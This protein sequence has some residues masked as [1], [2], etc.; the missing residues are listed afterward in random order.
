MAN[1]NKNILFDSIFSD[2]H[3]KL[4][5]LNNEISVLEK[6]YLTDYNS[7]EESDYETNELSISE[8]DK[9]SSA[10][11]DIYVYVNNFFT[12]DQ[13]MSQNESNLYL[14]EIIDASIYATEFKNGIQKK[15]LTTKYKFEGI[16]ICQ[17]PKIHSL[18]GHVSNNAI[19]FTSILNVLKFIM[20]FT[21]HHG[22]PLS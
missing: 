1:S 5:S 11:L 21:N 4:K 13:T 14:L 15:Y 20:N 8:T 3:E 9:T 16:S 18:T 17:T 22:L 12:V 10:S 7:D 6:I 2:I 19:S